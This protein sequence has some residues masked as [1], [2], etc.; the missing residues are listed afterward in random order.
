MI[1][2]LTQ[3]SSSSETQNESQIVLYNDDVNTF[4]WV[5]SSLVE[6]CDHEPTQAEQCAIFVHLKGKYPVKSGSRSDLKP[7]CDALLDR[8]L[9]AE[10][11]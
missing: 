2:E 8:G 10:I 7:R 1:K 9:S 5:I 4:D 6:V 11:Q 3:K